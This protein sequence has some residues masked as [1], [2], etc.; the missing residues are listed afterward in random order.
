MRRGNAAPRPALTRPQRAPSAPQ[1]AEPLAH[2]LQLPVLQDV[3]ARDE[4]K[5]AFVE[6]AV[7]LAEKGHNRRLLSLVDEFGKLCRGE[8]TPDVLLGYEL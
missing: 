4:D 5:R 3:S 1:I 6:L 2:A 8:E 7:S